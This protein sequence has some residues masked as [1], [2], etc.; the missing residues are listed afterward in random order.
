MA[1]GLLQS[2]H[3]LGAEEAAVVQWV[4]GPSNTRARQPV[5]FSPLQSL[6]VLPAPEP[7]AGEQAAWRQKIA[8]PLFGVRG[9][10]GAV[11][12]T[13]KRA[14]QVIGPLVST[15]SLAAGPHARIG[16]SRQSSRIA[17]QLIQVVA[18]VR[19]WSGIVNAAELA[20]L[21]GWPVEGVVVP[22]S[23]FTLTVPPRAL[24]VP[25]AEPKLAR[26]DRILGFSLHPR[27]KKQLLR[28]P[29]ASLASHVHVI[30]PTGAGKSTTLARWALSDIAAER[31]LFLVE[32]KGDL[33]TDILSRLPRSHRSNVRIIEPGEAGPVVGF[34]P[35]AGRRE[36]AERR[37]DSLMNLFRELFG[38]G[39]GPRSADI[40]LHALTAICRLD[41]GT[42]TD[43]PVFL[44]NATFRRRVLAD[45]SDPLVLAPWAAW[46]DGLSE[47]ERIRV[48]M[49]LL[50]KIRAFTS[51][52]A[53]R[54]LLGQPKPL[55]NLDDLFR[56]P[57]VVL[58][59]L[60]VGTIGPETARLLGSLLLGQL[61]V[62]IQRQAA[63]PAHQRRPVS[64][65]VDEWQNFT[66]GM[67]FA[68][69]LATARGMNTGFT[70]A[71]Q[72]LAQLTPSL[73][74]AVLANTRSRLAF[75]P[76]DGDAKALAAV[77]GVTADDL[78]RLPAYQAVARVLIKAAP[79]AP[80]TV[81][82]PAL[83]LA[84]ADA[85]ALR[86]EHADRYGVDPVALDHALV[87]RW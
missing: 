51:R 18:G 2:R 78:T 48:V 29:A 21:L 23:E 69:M 8:E 9:R 34:N 19:T 71:H 13:L 4:V 49:P 74:A 25:S 68:D 35:L 83:P 85:S 16:A 58:V 40:L 61:A 5:P 54:R 52:S 3:R 77:L 82:T 56:G 44:T 32:P 65:V 17:E 81:Q 84:N 53:V 63:V 37:A 72:H 75:R 67:D 27:S 43:V 57:A 80:F 59:N 24:L 47:D 6:G 15:L 30:A 66:A 10:A 20:A 70:L 45:V 50:N 39:I 11:A 60:N 22:G 87:A 14:A 55:F 79:S 73:R 64:V 46:F 12:H 41:D 86:R 62:A 38:S 76:A 7:D 42:L 28:L 1:A 36:D 31:S 26:D 33:V